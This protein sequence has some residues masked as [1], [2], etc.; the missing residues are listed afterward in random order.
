MV[1]MMRA[2][3]K[4]G[5]SG[6]RSYFDPKLKEKNRRGSCKKEEKET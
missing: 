3:G 6:D 2:Y 1:M 4:K 5:Q